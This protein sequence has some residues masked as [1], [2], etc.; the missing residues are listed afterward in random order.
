MKD[1]TECEHRHLNSL[2]LA[3]LFS[4]LSSS[5]RRRRLPLKRLA[6]IHGPRGDCQQRGENYTSS[7]DV[8][9]LGELLYNV[10][11]R[12]ADQAE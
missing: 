2:I 6:P 12:Q 5:C 7:E 3:V 4:I 10:T 8:H 9:R 11:P 1:I